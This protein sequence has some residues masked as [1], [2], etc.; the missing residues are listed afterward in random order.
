[1]SNLNKGIIVMAHPETNELYTIGKNPEW[2][3]VRVETA[4]L[5]NT[6][7]DGMIVIQKRVAFIRMRV[8]DAEVLKDAKLLAVGK[9]FP[10]PGKIIVQESLVPFHDNQAP[11]LNP[12]T[13]EIVMYQGEPVYRNSI[14]CSDTEAA[15]ELI[16]AYIR[17]M[18]KPVSVEN[19]VVD[20]VIGAEA[21]QTV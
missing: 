11:K 7:G 12:T 16:A 3:T 5:A 13:G 8:A 14:F 19:V 20:E 1:M 18:N 17:R 9:V 2:C 15:D 10:M 6:S 21:D 4:T